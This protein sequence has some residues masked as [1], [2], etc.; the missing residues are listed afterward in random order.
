MIPKERRLQHSA[1][2]LVVL[3][4]FEELVLYIIGPVFAAQ[5][6]ALKALEY[7]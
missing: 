6:A 4:D 3:E 1:S 5:S 2:D 7:L